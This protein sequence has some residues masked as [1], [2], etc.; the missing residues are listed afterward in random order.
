MWGGDSMAQIA[1]TFVNEL[2][3]D[4]SKAEAGV[5]TYETAIGRAAAASGKLKVVEGEAAAA[6]EKTTGAQRIAI[7]QT[8]Q[9]E[10][11][12]ARYVDR[13]DPAIRAQ[14]ELARAETAVETA[15]RRGIAVTEQQ[16]ATVE[17]LRQKTED[18]KAAE[19]GSQASAAAAAAQKAAQDEQAAIAKTV[20]AWDAATREREANAAMII[21]YER[22]IADAA[23]KAADVQQRAA[24]E[25][26]SAT[27]RAAQDAATEADRV[28][29][30]YA[31][32][33]ASIDPAIRRQQ[34]YEAALADV[35]AYHRTAGSSSQAMAADM[36][37]V[38][39]AMSP[40]ALA[41]KEEAEALEKLGL[42][43]RTLTESINP[44]ARA[45]R[46]FRESLADADAMLAKGLITYEQHAIAAKHYHDAMRAAQTAT[47]ATAGAVGTAVSSMG[48]MR[49]VMGQL[50]YQFQD[51]AVQAQMGTNALVIFAQQGSQIA[52]AFGPTGAIVGAVI[53]VVGALGMA[54]L[55]LKDDVNKSAA[56][57]D[58]FGT[59]LDVFKGRAVEAGASVDD[60]TGTYRGLSAELRG[61]SKLALQ[62]DLTTLNKKLV[63]DLNSEWDNV[64]IT[65][66]SGAGDKVPAVLE[67]LVALGKD[68]DVAA[69]LGRLQ[70]LNAAGAIKLMSDEDVRKLLETGEAIRM[71]EA[72]MAD[73]ENRA[74]P[75]QKALLGY[76][77]AAKEAAKAAADLATAQAR[78]G[79]SMFTEERD[80]D[81]KIKALKGGESAMK[82]YGEEQVRSAA[83][84]K[85]Y[86]ANIKAGESTLD[87]RSEATRIATKAAEAYRLEQQRTES[88]KAANKAETQAERDA[89]AYAKAYAKVTDELD[90]DIEA[91]KRL[92]EIAGL[93]AAEQR[94]ANEQTRIAAELAKAH[95]TEST[96]EG[97]AIAAKVKEAERWK[98]VASD[99]ATLNSAKAGLKYAQDELALNNLLPGARERAVRSL[100]IQREATERWGA[101]AKDVKTEWIGLQEQIADTQAVKKFEDD[102]RDVAKDI[103]KDVSEN[104]WDQI[105]GEAKAQDAL[106]LFKN[107]FKRIAIEALNANIILPIT[108]AVVGSVPGLFGITSPTGTAAN[109]SA[110]NQNNPYGGA[111]NSAT[112]WGLSKAG[113]WAMDK[114]GLSGVGTS[115]SGAIDVWG[116]ANLGIGTTAGTTTGVL[117]GGG[118]TSSLAAPAGASTGGLSGLAGGIGAGAAAGGIIGGLAGTATNS[119]AV[120]GLSGAAAGGLAT[121]MMMGS[122]FGPL[123]IAA[124]AIVGAI[125][126]MIGTQKASVGPNAAGNL[127]VDSSGA[128][129]GPS[130]GDNGMDGSG[131]SA[132]TD[133]VSQAVNT[134]V[135]GVGGSFTKGLAEQNFANV[136]FFEKD[137]KWT[138][139]NM[140]G[141]DTVGDKQQFDS[142][143]AMIQALIR[144]TLTRL[145]QGGQVTG[146]NA[147]VRT[148]LANSKATKAED[149]ATDVVF[150]GGFRDQ[151]ALLNASMDPTNNLIKTF[152]D[153]AKA[154]GEQVKTSILDWHDKALELGLAT[155]GEL[156]P[157]LK[158]GLLAMMGLGPAAEPLIGMAAV[159]KQATIEFEA[160]KPALLS[161]GY[162]TAE[163]AGLAIQYTEK[164]EKAYRDSVAYVQRQGAAAI[165][166]LTD[167]TFKT[168]A[169]DR[170]QGAGLDPANKAVQGLAAVIGNV[171]AAAKAG[172]LTM[173]DERWALGQLDVQ[174]AAGILTADQYGTAVGLL[175][176]AW[177]DSANAAQKAAEKIQASEDLTVRALR[178]M[179]LTDQADDYARGL[180]HARD[181]QTAVTAG[182]DATY[183]A[184]LKFVQWLENVAATAERAAKADNARADIFTRAVAASGNSV[185]AATLRF[186]TDAAQQRQT[187]WNNGL[188]GQ[189]ITNLD[190]V[191]AAERG[192]TVFEAAQSAYLSEVDRQIQAINDNTQ[193][194]RDVVSAN[195]QFVQSVRQAAKDRLLNDSISPLSA[196]ERLDEATRQVNDVYAK[197]LN[198]DETARGQIV[199]LLNTRDELSRGYN[200][201]TNFTDFWDSQA[202]LEALGLTAS[203]QLDSAQQAVDIADRQLKELQA[204]RTAAQNLGQR[205]LFS[206]DSLNAT[207]QSAYNDWTVALNGLAPLLGQTGKPVAPDKGGTTAA[208]QAAQAMTQWFSQY[209]AYRAKYNAGQLTPQQY[210]EEG[211]ALFQGKVNMANALPLDPIIWNAF[212]GAAAAGSDDGRTA[213]WLRQV[214]HDKGVPGF[215]AGG[216]IPH[217]PGVSILG[218]DS[219]PLI[220]MPGEGVVNL[221]GMGVLGAD[222]LAALN[223][224]RWPANDRWS[225]NITALRSAGSSGT[226]SL[227]Q[228]LD[229]AVSVLERILAA[230]EAGDADNAA[231]TGEAVTAIAKL[232]RQ[233]GRA[234][235]P[236]G[237][238]LR[239]AN[240]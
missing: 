126:G 59:M 73:L 193:S 168:G 213:A 198:G 99:T 219:V 233:I 223:A 28:A 63:K 2:S 169:L 147:D 206:L 64:R 151:L 149:L 89:K 146:F 170:L 167:P 58:T 211:A 77:D 48:G 116:A 75:A 114:M 87:A 176:T 127:Y 14:Q 165:N 102:V 177:T 164:A 161:L 199:A 61:L 123:G 173:A 196:K 142:Q 163:V 41:A 121:Y 62:S 43:A 182:F 94:A 66:I 133:G 145:D 103:G 222:G 156:V 34:A 90:R 154:I 37:R 178:G 228:R 31:R 135:A 7:K 232:T 84:S 234:A 86:D 175:T 78:A 130:A 221:R 17:K 153:Q 42:K 205:Q 136:K 150:A 231:A 225:G 210:Q 25:R 46:V 40:A 22:S 162:S 26:A 214:A 137:G 191:L 184:G 95:T 52:G 3:V 19:S 74:T 76:A 104:L 53:A 185:W 155:E 157:A 88:L 108:T 33:T 129:S 218:V 50:G 110:A 47:G 209:D 172:T 148:A 201:S 194:A 212:I 5:R 117:T 143:E 119:K 113:G 139:Q 208:Q 39:A 239:T 57:I 192:Q 238:R 81:A 107:L 1:E 220:G 6:I 105:T 186:D 200:E 101:A 240:G 68:K 32:V 69:F 187:A 179:G 16:I 190:T 60:L 132:I 229:R 45:Q 138:L 71:A 21:A 158:K 96:A 80:L 140:T 24:A 230:T 30:S 202:K 237:S 171:E 20:S 54:F 159:T 203:D 97:K 195:S 124:G 118:A 67:A 197:A 106:T 4:A 55:G 235:G 82:A 91:Q 189:D 49:G 51:I 10:R 128:K 188:R 29:A 112:N 12:L 180:Q 216:I 38:K 141:G 9:A 18:L 44:A 11:A 144:Q 111:M 8:E 120:G 92:A 56:D 152:T 166:G 13:F 204:A 174:L 224:G 227:E 85:A 160:Y 215:A 83:Y 23:Q 217:I 183:L 65:A 72:R 27:A 122:A 109:Q 207:M 98:A 93:G 35:V 131:M 125:M 100:Q 236:A 115:L 15:K 70:D 79:A 226:A 134:I 36:D 181:Y